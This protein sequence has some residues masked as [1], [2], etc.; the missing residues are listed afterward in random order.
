MKI[1]YIINKIRQ[2]FKIW[3]SSIIQKKKNKSK[4]EKNIL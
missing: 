4:W 2:N 3:E 1:R